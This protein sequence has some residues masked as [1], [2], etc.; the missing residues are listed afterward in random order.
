MNHRTPRFLNIWSANRSENRARKYD[1]IH[2]EYVWGNLSVLVK[3]QDH[4]PS[5]GWRILSR[6]RVQSGCLRR[7]MR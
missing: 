7:K 3:P 5:K 6:S 1:P 2:I 4:Y